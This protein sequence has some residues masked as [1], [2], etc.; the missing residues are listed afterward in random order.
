MCLNGGKRKMVGWFYPA[1]R[2]MGALVPYCGWSPMGGT[3]CCPWTMPS[4]A[5]GSQEAHTLLVTPPVSLPEPSGPQKSP[6]VA[7]GQRRL[8]SPS[9]LPPSPQ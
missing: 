2:S 6:V 7:R 4:A 3:C 9:I 8:V 5:S 1:H